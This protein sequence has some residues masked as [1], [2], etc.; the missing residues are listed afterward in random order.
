ML[1]ATASLRS[2]VSGQLFSKIKPEVVS[3]LWAI[4]VSSLSPLLS[5][6][7]GDLSDPH[8]ADQF[9]NI[10]EVAVIQNRLHNGFVGEVVKIFR[11]P[12]EVRPF[13]YKFANVHTLIIA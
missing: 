2:G 9:F 7:G 10:F 12:H 4:V 1:L 13:F 11:I 8:G 3:H 5:K 6:D